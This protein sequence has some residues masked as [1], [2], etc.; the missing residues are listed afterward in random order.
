MGTQRVKLYQE[1]T[2]VSTIKREKKKEKEVAVERRKRAEKKEEIEPQKLVSK[3]VKE[4]KPKVRS[5]KYLKAASQIDRSKLYPID[6][7][8]SL[9]KK[10]SYSNFEGKVEVAVVV[11]EKKTK[12]VIQKTLG[13]V[14]D[15]EK[16]IK[17]NLLKTLLAPPGKVVKIVLSSTMGPGIKVEV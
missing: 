15:S 17:E 14:S 2:I 9:V 12:K 5:K 6:E 1:P 7:A 16:E 8:I 13:K 10:T 3:P 11:L 4:G